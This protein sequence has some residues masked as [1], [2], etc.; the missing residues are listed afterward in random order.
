MISEF[1]NKNKAW[2][3][4]VLTMF[5]WILWIIPPAEDAIPTD[6]KASTLQWIVWGAM[7]LVAASLFQFYFAADARRERRQARAVKNYWL[8]R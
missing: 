5:G 8:N 3:V 1:T 7:N 2:T 6:G 4:L